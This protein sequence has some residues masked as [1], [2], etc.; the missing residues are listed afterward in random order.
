MS[1]KEIEMPKE[2]R[3]FMLE[4]AEE[5]ALGFRNGATKQYRYKRLHIREYDDKF[6]VH[7]D[8]FD[9]RSDPI[10]HLIYD[11]PEVIFGLGAG[12][13]VG[14]SIGKAVHS[15]SG[16]KKTSVIAGITTGLVFGFLGLELAKKIKKKFGD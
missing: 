3:Q 13:I 9:P 1:E 11:A 4:G 16:S 8:K 15:S 12:V 5:T 2:I 10:N 6:L 14:S 7:V